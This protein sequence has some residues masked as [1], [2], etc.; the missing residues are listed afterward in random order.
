MAEIVLI[1]GNEAVGKAA[2]MAGCTHY[3]GYPITPQNE[4]PEY[5]SF[6]LP[7]LG[8][9]F[10]Q[11]ESETASINMMIGSAAAGMRT[12]T[13]TSGPGYSLMLEGL[14]HFAGMELPAVL[15]MV[16][17][18]GPGGGS[19]ESTQLDY[20]SVTKGGGH[21]GY[22]NIVLA[23][24]DVQEL[25]DHTQLAFDLADKYRMVA[26][27][28]AEATLG[29]M[30][31]PIEIRRVCAVPQ[32]E[33][34][35]KE[36]A[37]KGKGGNKKKLIVSSAA[38]GFGP[39]N[40]L[41]ELNQHLADKYKALALNETRYEAIWLE[42]ADVVVA[43]FGITAG[44]VKQALIQLR[45]EGYKAGM[46]RPITLFPFPTEVIRKTSERVKKFLVVEGNMGQMVEDVQLAVGA[47][48]EVSFLGK[49]EGLISPEEI[50]SAIKALCA[51]S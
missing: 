20:F 42:G 18:G 7:E 43:A 17:R 49:A 25:F 33:L 15:V 6:H 28:L 39:F 19:L 34:P 35:P 46:I 32:N 44:G 47:K 48:A 36:W 45:E 37:L 2:I 13:S 50:Y 3:Y 24:V 31:E 40:N 9:T 23:P 12:M 1:K 27:V 38:P 51:K 22:R 4:I 14:S 41:N 29:N 30:A 11:A 16:S 5:M 26:I 10:I 21:G 8:G